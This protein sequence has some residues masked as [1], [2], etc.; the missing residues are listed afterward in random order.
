VVAVGIGPAGTELVSQAARSA[1]QGAMRV[2]V[3]T[4]RHPSAELVRELARVPV[5]SFDRIYEEAAT[6][7][8]VYEQIVEVLVSAASEA[9]GSPGS[10]V[11]VVPGSPAVAERTV[12]LL[13]SDERVELVV[14]PAMSFLDLVWERLGVDPVAAS[15]RI[16]DGTD[17]AA[18]AAGQRGPLLVAQTH[19]RSILSEVKLAVEQPPAGDHAAVLL[20]HLGLPDEVVMPVAWSELDR[21]SG[22]EPDHLTS[23]WIADLETPVA[24]EIVRL[25]ELVRTLRA[26][27]PWDQ[28]QTHGSLAR[29]LLEEAYEALDAIEDVARAAP[30]VPEQAIAHLEEELGDLVFQVVFHSALAAEEGWFT[31]G[32]VA[33]RLVGK[34]VG[35]HPHVFGDAVA[36][37]PEDVARR[38]EVLKREEQGRSSVTDGIPRTFPALALAAKLQRK[39]DSLRLAG[40]EGLEDPS[41][42]EDRGPDPDVQ[43]IRRVLDQLAAAQ[44]GSSGETLEAERSTVDQVGEALFALADLARRL[45]VDPESALRAR[46]MRF[47]DEIKATE[48]AAND[49]LTGGRQMN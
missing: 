5:V 11:Y 45:G 23:V 6:F 13:R 30:D 20:H 40:P 3:R 10:V 2:F 1:I 35:R 27:C 39:A 48:E 43:L 37:T 21:A 33:E 8:S 29:H 22:F 47:I 28:R 24:S 15:V 17:F 12:E 42:P 49:P 41:R 4:E 34:L 19:S 9:W 38:W 14:V 25:V 31:L 46:S 7:A 44:G 32:D 26:E 36:H 18:Q 16:V